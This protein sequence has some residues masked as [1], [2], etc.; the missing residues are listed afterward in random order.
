MKV[1]IYGTVVKLI[2][3][4]RADQKLQ[5]RRHGNVALIEKAVEVAPH[6]NPVPDFMT[7]RLMEWADVRSVKG[8]QR[9]IAGYSAAPLV[10]VHD[11]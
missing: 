8:G 6:Q 10:R 3:D 2:A 1:I 5:P 9:P 11:H 7:L 4:L